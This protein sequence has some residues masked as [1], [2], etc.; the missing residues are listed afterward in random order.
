M[1]DQNPQT[2]PTP[3]P[4]PQQPFII[5]AAPPP[6]FPLSKFI[7]P[8]SFGLTIVFFLFTF[9]D[10]KCMGQPIGS[11]SGFNLVAGTELELQN[12]L[13]AGQNAFSEAM[14]NMGTE[15]PD[16]DS[17]GVDSET[18]DETPAES[19]KMPPN[20]WAIIAL[21]AAT[22]G[23]AIQFSRL[24]ERA[25]LGVIAGAA[26]FGSLTL[27][28]ITTQLSLKKEMEGMVTATFQFGYWAALLALALA[29]G[30]CFVQW[31]NALSAAD[32]YSTS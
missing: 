19:K 17:G 8:V 26:G 25:I 13:M 31:R 10:F 32:P 7:V 28:Q 11:V 20:V 4:A 5:Q 3:E 15:Q 23:L 16:D 9:I 24:K 21:L 14:K 29:A 27:L 2:S 12:S 30:V 18:G 1:E 6:A 22:F